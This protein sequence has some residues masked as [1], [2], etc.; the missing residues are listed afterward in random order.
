MI[1][2]IFGHYIGDWALQNDFVSNNKGKYWIIMLA[3]CMIWTACVSIALEYLG[4]LTI[5]KMLFLFSGHWI[6]DKYKGSHIKYLM[7]L[8]D[9]DHKRIK[10]DKDATNVINSIE[11]HNL[12]C[13]YIDQ[14]WHLIQCIIVYI[15]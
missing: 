3:H 2:V 1:W 11:K 12:K 14:L 9:V 13:L 15:F 4:I 10:E 6:M 7:P 8:K 5:W